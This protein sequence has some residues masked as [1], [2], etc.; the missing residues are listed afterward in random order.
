MPYETLRFL[1]AAR[2]LVDHPLRET[3][4]VGLNLRGLVRGATTNAFRKVIGEC[5]EHDVDF[6][7]L[8]GDALDQSDFSI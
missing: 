8:T 2:A 5:L 1:H 4:P 7:L 3:G 6:L